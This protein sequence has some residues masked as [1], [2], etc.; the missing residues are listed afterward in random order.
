MKMNLYMIEIELLNVKKRSHFEFPNGQN[1]K[2]HK[3]E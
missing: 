1:I 2:T 3:H